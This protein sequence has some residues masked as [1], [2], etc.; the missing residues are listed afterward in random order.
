[1]IRHL[2]AALAA[3]FTLLA[4][5]LAAVAPVAT[6]APTAQTIT[7]QDA[8]SADLLWS[9]VEQYIDTTGDQPYFDTD[10]ATADGASA[11]V[12]AAGQQFNDYTYEQ[13]LE[14]QPEASRQTRAL[15]L[16]IWGYW[17]GPG[18]GTDGDPVQDT[19]DL[20]CMHHDKCYEAQGYFSAQCDQ[21]LLDEID[22]NWQAMGRQERIA[23][24]AVKGYFT[25]QKLWAK[26]VEPQIKQ[27]AFRIKLTQNGWYVARY[28]I[29]WQEKQ[30]DGTMINKSWQNNNL[31]RTLGTVD[32]LD[33]PENATAIHVVAKRYTG[34][35]WHPWKVTYDNWHPG[36]TLREINFY[37][38]TFNGWGEQKVVTP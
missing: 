14:Q 12:L 17:C 18:Y 31:D 35:V 4:V 27:N 23:A 1:M 2:R 36:V 21:A 6:A 8:T 11:D 24:V 5:S 10:K 9:A 34:W 37:G 15:R 38:T 19:L 26:Q 30:A 16:P 20:A 13:Y 29:T 22:L 25:L 28:Q 3:L 33:L 7:A 32:Y